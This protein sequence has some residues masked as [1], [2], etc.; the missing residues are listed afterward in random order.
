MQITYARWYVLNDK[1]C[2]LPRNS[3][4][5]S[6]PPLPFPPS[7]SPAYEKKRQKGTRPKYELLMYSCTCKVLFYREQTHATFTAAPTTTTTTT[8]LFGFVLFFL[9]AEYLHVPTVELYVSVRY[10]L[11]V[12]C[13]LANL[14]V[15][16]IFCVRLGFSPPSILL[17]TRFATANVTVR[18]KW[19]LPL[20]RFMRPPLL[21]CVI[22]FQIGSTGICI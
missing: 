12:S 3:F 20:R 10:Y 15:R 2:S 1:K 18:I 21:L 8:S 4:F 19:F 17:C 13:A 14:H 6:A 22:R 11:T 5:S 7:I 16:V 9:L